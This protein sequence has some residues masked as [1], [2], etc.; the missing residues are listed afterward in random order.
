M[1]DRSAIDTISGYF[2]QF[3]KTIL[4]ILTSNDDT[5]IV[6]EGVEDIDLISPDETIAIQCKYYEKTAYNHSII[7]KPIMLM[8]EHYANI[9]KSGLEPIKYHIYGHY[10]SG[11]EKLRLPLSIE[12]LKEH[13]LTFSKN[14]S[15][16]VAGKTKTKRI[17]HRF[18]DE[19]GLTDKNLNDFIDALTIDIN[20]PTFHTQLDNIFCQLCEVF[21]C[22]LFEAENFYYNSGLKVIKNLSVNQAINDRKITKKSF[23]DSI[24]TKQLFFNSW[25]VHYNG[26]TKYLTK[27]KRNYFSTGLNTNPYERFFL[28]ETKATDSIQDIKEIIRIIQN[29][30]SKLSKFESKSFCPYVYLHGIHDMKKQQIKQ[31]LFEEG[32]TFKDGYDF[33]GANFRS[34]SLLEQATFQNNIKLKLINSLED[35]NCILTNVT[36]TKEV[37][38]FFQNAS[39]YNNESCKHIQIQI[40]ETMDIKGIV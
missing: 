34:L 30:W 1:T 27:I 12:T 14:E 18:Y 20:A 31:E 23:L 36:A 32:L 22:D 25:Y 15:V 24:D 5:I 3:D 19:L 28:L 37:Y 33:L 11:H 17:T 40:E 7:K 8:V 2:Y 6:V 9:V 38:Q 4:D 10:N 39:F 29:R 26:K 13:F 16:T 35:L 21:G